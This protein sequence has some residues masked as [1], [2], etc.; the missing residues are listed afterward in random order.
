MGVLTAGIPLVSHEIF[1][2][3]SLMAAHQEKSVATVYGA[4]I[5]P[6]SAKL[7]KEGYYSWP[8]SGFDAEGR[9]MQYMKQIKTIESQLHMNIQMENTPL[10]TASDTEIFIQKVKQNNP[11]GLLLIPFKKG[12]WNQVVKIIDETKIPTVVLATLGVL[13]TPHVREVKYRSGV[14]LISSLDNLAAVE[15]G[16]KMIYTARRMKDSLILNITGAD[17]RKS[18]VPVIGTTVKTIP[19]QRFYDAF[20][21][22]NNNEQVQKLAENYMHNAEKIVEPSQ[23]DIISAAKT[24]FTFKNLISEEGADAVMMNCL[25]GLKHPHQHVPPCM[26]FMSLRD[27]GIPMGCESDQDA[28]LTM[29]LQQYLFN[30]P[31]FQHNPAVDTEKNHYFGAH[32][33]APSKMNG[34]TK[35]AEPFILRNHAEAGWGVVPRVLMKPDQE[36]TITKYLSSIDGKKPQLLLYSGTII[37]CPPT[38]PAGGC[39]TN[40]ETTINELEDVAQLKGHHL[41]MIYGNYVHEFKSFCQLYDIEVVV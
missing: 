13:L 12:H 2:G 34:P 4:F 19:H 35:A 24:Y 36:V 11:D 33:T 5:Y 10:D 18:T 1:A 9:Q 32:C 7:K 37:G 39:R 31:G 14:Y 16:M 29:M 28:T 17:T 8:G 23:Q 25:P 6:A 40:I 20:K 21:K 41:C 27:E 30:R 38:P 26:G 15:K 22:I 3:S